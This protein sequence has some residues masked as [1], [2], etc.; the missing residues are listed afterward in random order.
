MD[1]HWPLDSFDEC[2]KML[3]VIKDIP[4]TQVKEYANEHN[5]GF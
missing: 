5:K 4:W 1:K 2:W 3:L